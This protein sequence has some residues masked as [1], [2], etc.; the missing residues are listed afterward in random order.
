MKRWQSTIAVLVLTLSGCQQLSALQLSPQKSNA[1]VNAVPVAA[2]DIGNGTVESCADPSTF[3]AEDGYWYTYCTRDPLNDE[4][5][6]AQG[7]FNFRNIPILRSANLTDWTYVGEA[8]DELPAW[9]D[10]DTTVFAPE[11][12]YVDG[13][14]YLYYIVTSASAEVSGAPN[15][16]SDQAIGVAT[17]PSAAGPWTD[18]GEAVVEPQYNGD[19]S[20]A[21]GQRDCN[22]FGAIDPEVVTAG[23]RRYMYFGGFYGGIFA[24]PLSE[25]G[26]A[27]DPAKQTRI[28][29]DNRY[30]GAEV[31]KKD[32]YYYLFVSATNCCNG[33][34]TGYSVFAGR[35]ASPLGPYVDRE[36]V[37]LLD[38]RVGGSVVLSM[39]GNR[40]V[41]TGHNTVLQDF[42]GQW[43]TLYHA[44]DRNDPYFA[45]AIGFTKRPLLLDPI[46]WIDGWPTV[47]G[48]NWASDSKQQGPAA[49]PGDRSKYKTEKF[50]DIRLGKLIDRDEFS[51]TALD[52]RWSWVRQ[53]AADQYR[54]AGGMLRFNTQDGDLFVDSNNAPVLTRPADRREYVFEARV[55]LDAPLD[56]CG[57]DCNFN[58]AGSVIYDDDDNFI[59]LVDVSI[60]NTRQTE[61]AKELSPAPENYPRYG[62]TVV[63]PPSEWT[64]LRIVKQL[65]RGEE[66]YTAYTRRDVPGGDWVRGG[67][68]THELGLDA[69]IGLVSF[70]GT[71]YTA[72]FDYVRVYRL[73][74]G[75]GNSS[76][77]Q[78]NI[79]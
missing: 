69:R 17:A 34:L 62:N 66:Y 33:P 7:D 74:T 24:R 6:N 2:P 27:T 42:D 61:F 29:I 79:D 78:G 67:T 25:D 8:L 18:S 36:G 53:P 75:T 37:S 4:D 65:V 68:W 26:L 23:A 73:K 60:F 45:S 14:Y 28:T 10:T 9:A 57:S 12:Q 50:R 31:V 46:D 35:S 56:K 15:C 11:I 55:K 19:Q 51:G 76:W 49:Q 16:G 77:Q 63:G 54:V 52:D 64:L 58:Q 40:W 47:R 44:V 13:T 30:E 5:R 20:K 22:F 32:G 3:Y 38:T 41:G 59:K 72:Y 71:G 48:G 1:Y 39:N 43:W 70:G 21:F